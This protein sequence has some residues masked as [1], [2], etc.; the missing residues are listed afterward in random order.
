MARLPNRV[1]ESDVALAALQIA[2]GQ[3][4]GVATFH[5]LKREVPNY[6]HLSAAD[7]VQ[8][9][10][11]PNEEVWEQLIRNIKS[12]YDTPG[13]FICEG[14]LTHVPRV[15]YRITDSGRRYLAR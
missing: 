1:T 7:H 11:R 15:G 6:V 14:Y 13:N 8:S 5:R 4:N 9:V 2:A 10:T 12:H 3:A